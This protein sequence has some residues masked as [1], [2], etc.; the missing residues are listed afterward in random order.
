MSSTSSLFYNTNFFSTSTKSSPTN[1]NLVETLRNVLIDGTT[2]PTPIYSCSAE[3]H[4]NFTK[5]MEHQFCHCETDGYI[6]NDYC[7]DNKKPSNSE[8]SLYYACHKGYYS[9]IYEGFFLVDSYPT[10]YGNEMDKRICNEHGPSTVKSEGVVF[11]NRHCA[12]RS[13]I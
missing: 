7:A 8:Y 9:D 11:I 5:S 13:S 12:Y 1:S 10:G 6:Y 4:C 3:G 2:V